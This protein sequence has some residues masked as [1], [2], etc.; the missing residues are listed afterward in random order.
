MPGI[1]EALTPSPE[2]IAAYQYVAGAFYG[3]TIA[4]ITILDFLRIRRRGG[5]FRVDIRAIFF[6]ALFTVLVFYFPYLAPKLDENLKIQ[7]IYQQA[8]YNV[9]NRI[10]IMQESLNNVYQVGTVLI[11]AGTG[12]KFAGA[13][14]GLIGSIIEKVGTGATLLGKKL[15]DIAN[16]ISMWLPPF[17][18]YLYS[19]RFLLKLLAD[20]V[21]F[22]LAIAG[23]T[24]G[25]L[26]ISRRLGAAMFSFFTVGHY[27]FPI[28]IV[29]AEHL[30][31]K[32]VG[33]V[34]PLTATTIINKLLV[35]DLGGVYAELTKHL[36]A[37]II[38]PGV[39]YG[40]FIA[41]LAEA[42][43][44]LSKALSEEPTYIESVWFRIIRT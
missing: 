39:L 9:T 4:V 34:E 40:I 11:A 37:T 43:N 30:L 7:Q 32:A 2:I 24:L 5:H 13:K 29:A 16:F 21:W 20:P 17:M 22:V 44:G 36:A 14:L 28:V 12:S 6:A 15:I 10:N 41:L 23:L 38:F 35:L 25:V 42:T 33:K 19:L 27:G 1:E 18:G 31:S 26:P 3:G 8:Y